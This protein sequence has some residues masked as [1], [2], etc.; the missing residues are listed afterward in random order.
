[1][2]WNLTIPVK[3]LKIPFN[4]KYIIFSDLHRDKYGSKA[5]DF[6]ANRELYTE[7]LKYYLKKGY[8]LIENGDG[9]ELW[10]FNLGEIIRSNKEIYD[11]LSKF[12]NKDRLHLIY[13]NHNID[14]KFRIFHRYWTKNIFP[15]LKYRPL[16]FIGDNI[17]VTHG[18]QWDLVYK[19]GFIPVRLIVALWKYMELIGFSSFDPSIPAANPDD[20]KRIDRRISAWG[21][22]RGYI[23]ICGHTHHAKF[24][25]DGDSYFNC[26]CGTSEGRITGLEIEKGEIILIEW[27]KKK[28]GGVRRR[29]I[30]QG[31]LQKKPVFGKK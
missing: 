31:E 24:K 30:Y 7:I 25:A 13:G 26:G 23:M 19:L 22:Q 15:G 10:Q 4:G 9:E 18:H 11:L 16:L 6:W 21:E 27:L 28:T 29:V 17:L 12:Y 20:G 1:M 14:M 5:G 3:P 8:T 2:N